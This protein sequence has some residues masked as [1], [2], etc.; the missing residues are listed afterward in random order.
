MR[1][2]D[3]VSIDRIQNKALWEGFQWQ[4]NLMKTNNSGCTP[5]ERKLFHGTD[6]KYIDAICRNNFD[7]RLCGAHGTAY[8]Q[9][10]YFARDAKYSH[11]YTDDLNVKAMFVARVLVG[12]FTKGS[13][14]YRRAPSKDGG[15]VN[16]YHSC[17]DDV[18]NPSIFVVFK[19][20]QIYPEYLLK[21]KA[22][23]PLV[24]SL[25]AT[26]AA[27]PRPAPRPAPTPR[28]VTTQPAVPVIPR[29]T[30]SYQPKA[31]VPPSTPSYFS[32]TPIQPKTSSFQSST[33]AQPNIS[34]YPRPTP[35]QPSA[36]LYQ[37]TSSL[38]QSSTSAQSSTSRYQPS[39]GTSSFRRVSTPPPAAKKSGDSCVIA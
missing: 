19:E 31:S 18:F 17:V 2:F 11:S 33:S 29:P 12:D 10:S 39:S 3:V 36:S 27:A 7:W 15:D 4:K 34:S 1:G 9:G 21:Y 28:T 26:A 13:S 38:Y 22:T 23:H 16:F 32:T 30:P 24:S 8:G 37:T 35:A 6:S 20:H 25:S 5:A 14:S